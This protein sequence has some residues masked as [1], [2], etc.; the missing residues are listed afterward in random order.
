MLSTCLSLKRKQSPWSAS[1]QWLS[2]TTHKQ[3]TNDI[4]LLAKCCLTQNRN[5]DA[6]LITMNF[7]GFTEIFQPS[8]APLP[9]PALAPTVP[10]CASPINCP[11]RHI[12]PPPM[13]LDDFCWW[14][15]LSDGNKEKLHNIQIA[16]LH[17][18][19]LISDPDF[20]GEGKLSIGE[21]ASV[22]DAQLRWNHD[23]ATH[24]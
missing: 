24:I 16:G 3:N 5:H 11:H 4:N 8:N 15:E 14:Y 13:K 1:T 12:P 19:C 21:L 23:I 18:L 22:H 9:A 17:I 6:P 7:P 20:W 2:K 10:A